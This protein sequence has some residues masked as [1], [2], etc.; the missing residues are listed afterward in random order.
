MV[1]S[2]TCCQLRQPK[3]LQNYTTVRSRNIP[4][5]YLFL[6]SVKWTP[7]CTPNCPSEDIKRSTYL[8]GQR[9]QLTSTTPQTELSELFTYATPHKQGCHYAY[10][11]L[12]GEAKQHCLEGTVTSF[13][14]IYSEIGK[15]LISDL[16]AIPTH[17]NQ[18]GKKM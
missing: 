11:V 2:F 15:P 4:R 18:Q 17:I 16:C 7:L 14:C 1:M 5:T 3:S 8:Q 12:S 9:R 13:G 6:Q 10:R